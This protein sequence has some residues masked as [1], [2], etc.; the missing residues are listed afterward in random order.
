MKKN[1][2]PECLRNQIS[3]PKNQSFLLLVGL[4]GNYVITFAQTSPARSGSA[5]FAKVSLYKVMGSHT[6]NIH[7]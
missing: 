1:S 3:D 7:A 6:L 4:C 5:L 2:R